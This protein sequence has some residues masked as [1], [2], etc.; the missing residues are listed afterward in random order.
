MVGLPQVR[1]HGQDIV[2][3]IIGPRYFLLIL[4]ICCAHVGAATAAEPS[5]SLGNSVRGELRGGVEL[6]RR[7]A[8][9]QRLSV[10]A[11]RDTGWG[12]Q[13]TV[14]LLVR[15]AAWLQ[16]IEMH[17]DVPL[18]VG[19]LSLQRG[20]D[21]R[22]SH[23]HKS[24]RDADLLLYLLDVETNA[25]VLPDEFVVLD[26]QGCGKV[27][28]PRKVQRVQLDL[29][30]MWHL[31]EVLVQDAHVQ[32]QHLYLA[33]PLTRLILA[34]AV[35][36]GAD[37]T[38]VQRARTLLSEPAHSGKH[39]DHLHVRLFCNRQ[40]KL[41]GCRDEDPVWPWVETYQ[42][43]VRKRVNSVLQALGE[44]EAATRIQAVA[45]L[46]W[47]DAGDDR[48]TQG[49]CWAAAWDLPEPATAAFAAL[50]RADRSEAVPCLLA[51]AAAV[52]M[53]AKAMELYELAL[54]LAK[55]VHSPVVL[56]LMG[57]QGPAQL[58]ALEAKDLSFLHFLA[59][60]AVAPWLLESAAVP[61]L[62]LLD[63]PSAPTRRVAHQAL[64]AL[65]NRHFVSD[66]AVRGWLERNGDKGRL[67]WLVEGFAAR[68]ISASVPELLVPRLLPLV[69]DSDTVVSLNAD[70][71]LRILVDD[72]PREPTS[73]PWLR[74][75]AWMRWWDVSQNRYVPSVDAGE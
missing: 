4:A 54:D 38:V 67:R 28:P 11:R 74:Q 23:S 22:W 49:L 43:D 55:P 59:A 46:T 41:A 50:R 71:W 32:I 29:P 10:V 36:Q 47:L 12:T 24:G 70:A 52:P 26:A 61:L 17:K 45:D 58:A 25:P 72:A 60:R 15:T 16:D 30:R 19:N 33:E 3:V 21:M 20:G 7:A 48:V 34:H 75:R 39:D 73:T 13:D 63:D 57:R 44:P 69:G 31:L 66:D 42:Y 5:L 6:P 9:L 64:E 51:A 62:G 14:D 56:P 40:D 1:A 8:G 53:T 35:R 27:G 65:V 37:P 2:H 68:G 18:R